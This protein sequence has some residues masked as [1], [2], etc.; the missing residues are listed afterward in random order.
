MSGIP[1]FNKPAFDEA[2]RQLRDAGYN[3]INPFTLNKDIPLEFDPEK[4]PWRVTNECYEKLIMNDL[5]AISHCDGVA[6]LDD[7]VRSIGARR[8]VT[9]AEGRPIPCKATHQWIIESINAKNAS[10]KKETPEDRKT[11]PCYT[12]LINYFPDALK[13]VAHCSWK[14]NQQHNPDQPVHWDRSKSSDDKD[15]LVRHLID[16]TTGEPD[17]DGISHWAK[18]AW[19]ALAVLQKEIEENPF[20]RTLS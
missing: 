11:Q 10:P 20:N 13:A 6:L 2:E 14:G 9:Y 3:V 15:A 8:E 16:A 5:H 17:T 19:R 7:W 4:G 18:V 12:G 1:G